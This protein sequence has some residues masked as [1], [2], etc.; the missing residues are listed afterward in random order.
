MSPPP[1]VM[2]PGADTDV[3]VLPVM[4]TPT[5]M[6]TTIPNNVFHDMPLG[7]IIYEQVYIYT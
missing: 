1:A 2:F 4:T 6:A 3:G 7:N 5:A